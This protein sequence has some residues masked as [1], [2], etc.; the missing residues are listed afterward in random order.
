MHLFSKTVW[1][2]IVRPILLCGGSSA[3][4]SMR[5][6]I[7]LQ[8]MSVTSL[9]C[10]IIIR[11]NKILEKRQTFFIAV[12]NKHLSHYWKLWRPIFPF[13]LL[14]SLYF[15]ASKREICVTSERS[16]INYKKSDEA[17][18]SRNHM[19]VCG[20]LSLFKVKNF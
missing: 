12:C 18:P 17:S 20:C 13:L 15:I 5:S 8:R 4:T 14:I 16:S 10:V 11:E 2:R 1:L 19:F 3:L 6:F 7:I 9:S